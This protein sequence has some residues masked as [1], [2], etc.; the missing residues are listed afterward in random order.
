MK[1]WYH[2]PDA[3]GS[4]LHRAILPSKHC[5]ED[6]ARDGI[7]LV[8]SSGLDSFDYDA[9]VFHRCPT[10]LLRAMIEAIKQAGK[11]VIWS[12]D[13]DYWHVP[14][15]N[16]AHKY[17]DIPTLDWMRDQA[18]KIIVSTEPL[19]DQVDRP[20]KTTVLPNLVDTT[21]WPQGQ[22]TP[23]EQVRILWAG[24]IHHEKDLDEIVPAVERIIAEYRERVLFLFWGDLPDALSEFVRIRYSHITM[25]VP[26]A[27]YRGS[28]GLIQSVPTQQYPETAVTL[29]PDIGLAPL[30]VCW[31]NGSK[32]N[33]KWLDYTMMGAAGIYTDAPPYCDLLPWEGVKVEQGDHEGWYEAIKRLIDRPEERDRMARRSM[34]RVSGEWTW[35]GPKR[36]QWLD[37]FR[38]VAA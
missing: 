37:F 23:N 22:R 27:R 9:F 6:L 28:L 25:R 33:L 5:S 26:A 8:G 10:P 38:K 21:L 16:P 20:D 7:H 15:W 35:S 30:S 36:Q 11:K 12:L 1:I 4:G 29:Q 18:D 34:T 19:A 24:S 2:L 32:S 17:Q 13:D 14:A 3:E 31:F